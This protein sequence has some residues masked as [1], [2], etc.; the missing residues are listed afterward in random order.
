MDALVKYLWTLT[1]P[2]TPTNSV[3]LLLMAEKLNDSSDIFMHTRDVRQ[4]SRN[5][6][7]GGGRKFRR[8]YSPRYLQGFIQDFSSFLGGSHKT[9]N[10]C[11]KLSIL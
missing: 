1:R 8:R 11:L 7:L 3:I 4:G 6:C 5:F 10:T 2:C 9:K